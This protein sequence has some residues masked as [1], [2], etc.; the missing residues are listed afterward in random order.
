MK[1]LPRMPVPPLMMTRYIVAAPAQDASPSPDDDEEAAPAQDASPSPD[2]EEAAP[3]Q[4]RGGSS[5]CP[6]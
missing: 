1:H 3:H 6:G 5:A 2:D 4:G